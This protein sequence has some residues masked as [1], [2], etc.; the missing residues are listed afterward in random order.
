MSG[1]DRT[2]L[3]A[4]CD[5][6]VHNLSELTP[7]ELAEFV[8]RRDGSECI[9]YVFRPDGSIQTASRWAWLWRW[10][11]PVYTGFAWL[12]ALVLPSVFSGCTRVTKGE[13]R[14]PPSKTKTVRGTCDGQ[15][16]LGR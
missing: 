16:I 3:C 4:R 6:H 7:Q 5:K 8:A 1:D 11:R 14:P 13:P 15:L 10:A 9:G 12:L 2:R